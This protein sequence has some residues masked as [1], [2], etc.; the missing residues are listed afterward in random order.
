[1]AL[2]NICDQDTAVLFDHGKG[3]TLP[4]DAKTVKELGVTIREM[5]ASVS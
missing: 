4:R 1:M 3:H 5:I 2:F